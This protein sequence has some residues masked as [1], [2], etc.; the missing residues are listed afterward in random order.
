MCIFLSE[1]FKRRRIRIP[2]RVDNQG[3]RRPRS[4][5]RA[6]SKFVPKT[7]RRFL[8]RSR[9]QELEE[10]DSREHTKS[11]EVDNI[12]NAIS[13]RKPSRRRF[14]PSTSTNQ[15]RLNINTKPLSFPDI[16]LKIKP[17][18]E[19]LDIRPSPSI[20]RVNFED[21]ETLKKPEE[22]E[23]PKERSIE[24]L[25]LDNYPVIISSIDNDISGMVI[26]SYFIH[27]QS[28]LMVT[29]TSNNIFE[30]V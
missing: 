3:V 29:V 16:S 27:I 22:P 21:E 24:A 1:I 9:N 20:S 18:P 15:Y 2:R 25:H 17:E 19:T 28:I 11:E 30:Q 6:G 10:Y 14:I 26:S 7:N 5:G 4:F 13:Q 8:F 12:N 23:E